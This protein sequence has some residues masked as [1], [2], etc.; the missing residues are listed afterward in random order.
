[1]RRPP[2]SSPE[3][4]KL[5]QTLARG[6]RASFDDAAASPLPDYLA[7]LLRRL[8][9]GRDEV[10]GEASEQGAGAAKTSGGRDR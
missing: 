6:L 10:Y 7:T 8:N 3:P 1:M 2:T 5:P 4:F 9:T